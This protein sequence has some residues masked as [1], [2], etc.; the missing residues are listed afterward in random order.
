MSLRCDVDGPW[1][2]PAGFARRLTT[3][4]PRVPAADSYGE[5]AVV[6]AAEAALARL[7]GKER[8]VLFATGTLANLLALDRLCGPR[9]RRV[10]VHPESHVLNDMGDA[11]ALVGRLMPVVARAEGAGFAATEIARAV[12]D[13]R[14]G[15]VAQAVGAVVVETPVR[16][17]R[18]AMFSPTSRRAVEQAA[19]EAGLALHLDG[20]RL[21]I[22]AAAEGRSIA[23]FCGPYRC[24]YLSLWKMFGLPFGAALAGPADLLDGI[25]HDRRRHGGALPQFWP[26]AAIVLDEIDQLEADWRSILDLGDRTGVE[27]AARGVAVE[28]VGEARTNAFWLRVADADGFKRAAAARGVMLGEATE[29]R[30]LVRANA[31]W[32]GRAPVEIA[33]LIAG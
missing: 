23:D 13:A 16:R 12:A 24:V 25:A 7:M 15:R 9:A 1:H 27:L 11:P 3:A 8:A 5:G 26:I 18:N 4:L 21:P 29:G 22:A 33:D 31:T 20:A 28:P 2:D 6:Q 30:V 19:S 32:L 14:G 10:L 17:L